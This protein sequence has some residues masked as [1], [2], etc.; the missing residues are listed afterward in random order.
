MGTRPDGEHL[1]A[2]NTERMS[3]PWSM[4]AA[5]LVGG[6]AGS[7]ARYLVQRTADGSFP[8]GTLAVNVVG[9]FLLGVLTSRVG[10]SRSPELVA[11]LLGI[12]G[13]GAFTTFSAL[14]GQVD[15]MSLVSAMAYVSGSIVI[16]AAAAASGIRFGRASV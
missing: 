15:G 3:K 5:V 10:R 11:A 12:G 6:L 8:W 1:A 9:A 2:N 14:V 16:G 4:R 7:V 13:L